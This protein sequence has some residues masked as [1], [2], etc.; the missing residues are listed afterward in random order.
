MQ[1]CSTSAG[2]LDLCANIQGGQHGNSM[3]MHGFSYAPKDTVTVK[4]G[5]VQLLLMRAVLDKLVGEAKIYKCCRQTLGD[6]KFV[7][8]AT[9]ATSN[10]AFF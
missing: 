7:D 1:L 2:Q 4:A 9:C 3:C 10:G 5:P 8:T 6:E